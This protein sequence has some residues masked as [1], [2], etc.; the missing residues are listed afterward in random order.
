MAKRVTIMI[1][2]ELDGR[3]KEHRARKILEC[4]RAY[5]YSAAMNDLLARDGA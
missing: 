3:V 1:D 2:D 5:S 4:N